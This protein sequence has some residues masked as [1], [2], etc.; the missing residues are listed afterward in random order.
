MNEY[1]SASVIIIMALGITVPPTSLPLQLIEV[2]A[3]VTTILT[4]VLLIPIAMSD[5]NIYL[6]W[7]TN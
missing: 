3:S 5:D 1:L 4:P 6:A 7:P 2:S